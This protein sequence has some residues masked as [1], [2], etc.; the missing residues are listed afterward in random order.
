[1]IPE[2]PEQQPKENPFQSVRFWISV[3]SPIVAI[4]WV[5]VAEAVPAL[6][7]ITPEQVTFIAASIV[8]SGAVFVAA[9]TARNT[10]TK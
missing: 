5:Y 1:M 2:Q 7:V 10:P 9:R 3:L 4:L 6:S 8:A